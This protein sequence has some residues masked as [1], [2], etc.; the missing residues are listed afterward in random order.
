MK[1]VLRAYRILLL[2][3]FMFFMII[4]SVCLYY[5]YDFIQPMSYKTVSLG[6]IT[7][8]GELSVTISSNLSEPVGVVL[9]SPSGRE[10][11]QSSYDVRTE[12]NGNTKKV[13]I[14]TADLGEWKARYRDERG[15]KI[16]LSRSFHE[17]NAA[18]L[19]NTKAVIDKD[20]KAVVSMKMTSKNYNYTMKAVRRKD[21]FSLT[22]SGDGGSTLNLSE[23]PYSGVWDFYLNTKRGSD[24]YSTMFSYTF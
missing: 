17:S 15:I 1:Y 13:N 8:P 7:K 9:L 4:G 24:T 11:T 12:I 22:S 6:E 18:I 21:G 14:L 16:S 2:I 23:Y 10:Y 19:V 3:L 20:K 5:F